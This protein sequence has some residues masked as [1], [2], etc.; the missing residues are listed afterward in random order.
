MFAW[1]SRQVAIFTTASVTNPSVLR[2]ADFPCYVFERGCDDESTALMADYTVPDIF[3]DDVYELDPEL[4][5]VCGGL[6]KA[7]PSLSPERLLASAAPVSHTTSIITCVDSVAITS[8][9]P[10]FHSPRPG[11]LRALFPKFRYAVIGADRTGSNFHVDPMYTAA[12]NTLLCG[13]KKWLLA[14]PAPE[15]ASDEEKAEYQS[16]LGEVWDVG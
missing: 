10:G 16:K 5:W 6:T 3:S 2:S 13:R 11:I 1:R 15:G 9:W 12:W 14:P 7:S 8:H 4:R